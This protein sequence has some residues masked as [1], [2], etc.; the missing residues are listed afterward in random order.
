MNIT[1][2]SIKTN[3]VVIELPGRQASVLIADN[4]F[5]V[6]WS[7]RK[8]FPLENLGDHNP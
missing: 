7:Q 4:P 2:N 5:E 1:E 3:N 6:L 8:G